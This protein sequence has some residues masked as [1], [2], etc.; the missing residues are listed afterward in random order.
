VG[1]ARAKTSITV[2]MADGRHSALDAGS[3]FDLEETSAYFQ[4]QYAAGDEW[5]TSL[6]ED[7]EAPEEAAEAEEEE[8]E[9]KK[10]TQHTRRS[11]RKKAEEE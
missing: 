5:I 10:A 2:P 3:V 9:E 4:Q 11:S 7:A 8:E 1:Y 6:V